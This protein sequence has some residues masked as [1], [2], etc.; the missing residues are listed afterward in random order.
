[1]P[2]R[3]VF[4]KP[5]GRV[6]VLIP[7]PQAMKAG[8]SEDDFINRIIAKDLPS[9][10]TSY[11]IVDSSTL[12]SRRFRNSWRHI[13]NGAVGVD[14]NSAREQVLQEVRTERDRRL[15]ISDGK[16]QELEEIGTP[17]EMALL[18]GKRQLLRDFPSR[19]SQ[20][21]ADMDLPSLEVYVPSW[22]E[23]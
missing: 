13:G 5:D 12:P 7:A 10:V 2:K 18:K 14:L 15:V 17:Q 20:E 1:M 4:E 19:V 3:V 11:G 16:K 22:P 9:Y 6:C 8:E 23:F 21:I